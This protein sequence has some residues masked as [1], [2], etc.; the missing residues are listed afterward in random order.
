[1]DFYSRILKEKR[2]QISSEIKKF[3]NGLFKIK[4]TREKV[5]ILSLELIENKEKIAVYSKDCDAFM[6]IIQEQTIIVDDEKKV[7]SIQKEVI[8]EEAEKVGVLKEQAL[9]D[10]KKAMPAL[11]EALAAL[12]SLNKK[13]LTEVKS[14]ASPPVKVE[15]VMEAVMILLGKSP[16][17]VESKKQ[18]GD[19][20]FLDN[21]KE[22]DKN[23]I[24]EQILKKIGK[25]IHDPELE[26]DKVGVVSRPARSLCLW[27]R[28]I[29]KYGKVWK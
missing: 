2:L 5:E 17:W 6:K 4:D 3:R 20:K 23:N 7:M 29:E 19:Q 14:Y 1:M 25:Y 21:L 18:L 8:S 11:E 22:Y 9:I 27:V 26:P 16:T 13:D 24:S 28:A 12:N 15:K 10:L